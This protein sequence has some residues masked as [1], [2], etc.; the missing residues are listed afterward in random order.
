MTRRRSWTEMGYTFDR[1]DENNK[2][3]IATADGSKSQSENARRE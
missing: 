3:S 2:S 1:D